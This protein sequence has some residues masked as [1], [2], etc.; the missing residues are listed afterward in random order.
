M[1]EILYITHTCRNKE[2][3]R[4][5]Q[6]VDECN[7]QNIPPDYKYCPACL[8]KGFKNADIK[9]CKDLYKKKDLLHTYIFDHTPARLLEYQ[10]IVINKALDILNRHIELGRKFNLRSITKQAI[11]IAKYHAE[12]TT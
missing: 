2:C 4:A 1:K 8:K 10:D 12:D 7:S 3:E 6:N 5:F 11:E 9:E